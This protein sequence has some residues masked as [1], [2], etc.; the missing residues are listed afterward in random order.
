MRTL[1]QWSVA[2]YQHMQ[3]LGILDHRCCELIQ[4]ELWDRVPEGEFHR[5]PTIYAKCIG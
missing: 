2:N 4:R 1:T 3:D 5:F